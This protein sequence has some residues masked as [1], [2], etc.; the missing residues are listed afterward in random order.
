MSSNNSKSKSKSTT[1]RAFVPNEVMK[2]LQVLYSWKNYYTGD[3][4]IPVKGTPNKKG[5][6]AIDIEIKEFKKENG[7]F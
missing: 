4:H 2:Q 7:L 5:A 6:K 1:K 3:C